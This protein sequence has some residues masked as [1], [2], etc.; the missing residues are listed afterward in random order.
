MNNILFFDQIREHDAKLVGGKAS[1]LGKLFNFG[2]S[3][4]K[5]F[6]ISSNVF[7]E[8]L[9]YNNI[10]ISN[11]K[12]L[13]TNIIEGEFPSQFSHELK[14][15]IN[16]LNVGFCAV[17]SSG[18]LE[19]GLEQSFAG[20]FESYLNVTELQV[21]EFVKK[22]YASTYSQRL[23]S[24]DC[25]NQSIAV[26]VQEMVQSSISGVVFTAN[27]INGNKQEMVIESCRGLGEILVSGEITPDLY[28]VSKL[29]Q[30]VLKKNR[31]TQNKM[32]ALQD[33]VN[34][35]IPFDNSS[36]RY[37]LSDEQIID[38]ILISFEIESK[39]RYECDIEWC[40]DQNY[41]L[42]ILQTR[43]ITTK[44]DNTLKK[45]DG[46][47]KKY[48]KRFSARIVSPIFEEANLQGYLKFF[49]DQLE[50]PFVVNDYHVYQPSVKQKCGEVDIWINNELDKKI[51]D[52][53]KYQI[54]VNFDYLDCVE[55]KYI[56]LANEFT[57][58]CSEYQELRFTSCTDTHLTNILLEF[59]ELNQKMTAIYNAPI[60]ILT[61]L[62]E[63]LY[64]KM[65]NFNY[66]TVNSDFLSVSLDGIITPIFK[67]E[68]EMIN[69]INTAKIKYGCTHWS[70]EIL[71]ISEIKLMLKKYHSNWLFLSCTDIIGDSLPITAFELKIKKM[72]DQDHVKLQN[73]LLKK[74]KSELDNV[75]QIIKNY[76]SLEY[77]IVYL[78]KWQFHRNNTTEHYYRD[79]QYLKNLL[80]EISKRVSLT[81]RELLTFSVPE[82]I[83]SLSKKN[84]KLTRTEAMSR[85][86]KGFYLF[87]KDNEVFLTSNIEEEHKIEKEILFSNILEGQVASSGFVKGIVKIIRDPVKEANKFERGDILVTSMTLPSFVPIMQISC[88]IITDEGGLL[89][90]AALISREMKK[91][92]V[93]GVGNATQILNDGDTVELDAFNGVINILDGNMVKQN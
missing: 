19:D 23:Q 56:K 28:V 60:L 76:K 68:I 20:M 46:G 35:L 92:C 62:G 4:P 10:N 27:P 74:Y 86:E 25:S 77:F 91:P 34:K 18:T 58:F 45:Y 52:H 30:K 31:G 9:N 43:P 40:Y 37:L 61:A 49:Q 21:C 55:N 39:F 93:I 70:D 66:E 82:I 83:E 15:A 85:L 41:N 65:Q 57:K 17:R 6:V 53:I 78:R 59:N 48:H 88:G 81:Y 89:C 71:E 12:E 24:Y 3:V 64:D 73:D 80:L 47:K 84:N 79:F 5:G 67:Q 22:C 11:K 87:E 2:F 26:I 72:Y 8:Y 1:S 51:I 75:N 50:L 90:H 16:K 54:T 63:K 38:L 33:G 32:L 69:I 36:S 42:K 7:T 29:T 14:C 44:V 13:I